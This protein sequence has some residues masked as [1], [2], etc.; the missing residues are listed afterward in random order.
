MHNPQGIHSDER[1]EARQHQMTP[2]PS[3]TASPGAISWSIKRE[4]GAVWPILPPPTGRDCS[5]HRRVCNGCEAS[6]VARGPWSGTTLCLL[7]SLRQN[8]IEGMDGGGVYAAN[9]VEWNRRK[10]E[11]EPDTQTIQ[12]LDTAATR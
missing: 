1:L 2:V 3:S 12:S 7:V 5:D 11:L 9:E 8:S 6:R 10:K 4:N